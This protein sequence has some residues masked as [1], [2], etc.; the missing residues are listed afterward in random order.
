MSIRIDLRNK[1]RILG[2]RGV[3]AAHGGFETFAEV[4]SLHLVRRGWDVVV[5]CQQA[6]DPSEA[7]ESKLSRDTWQGVERIHIP[8]GL[9]G[10]AGTI[11][12]D[13]KCTW[14]VLQHE[15]CICLILGYNT[16][17][18]SLLYRLRGRLTIMNMDGLEWRRSKWPWPVR[19]WFY[20]NERFGC[21][22]SNHL[23]ADNPEIARRLSQFVPKG[24]VTMIPYGADSIESADVSVLSRFGVQ[25]SRYALV[26]ARAEPE[27]S[28]LEIVSAFSRRPRGVKLI[29]I[30]NYE[31]KRYSYHRKVLQAASEEVL[32]PG[33]IYEAKVIRAL[34]YW[35]TLY[36]HGHRVGGTNPSLV[37]ALGAG[38]PV[39][40]HDNSFNRW[41][42]GQ[43]GEY[44][45]DE[46]S[47]ARLLDQ[48]LNNVTALRR[49]GAASR[50]RHA[51]T[52]CWELPLS[53]YENL[54]GQW[55]DQVVP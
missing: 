45:Q 6:I 13:L 17:M 10:P 47:C 4:L 2:T 46:D 39:I 27:N 28:I 23:I 53:T 9:A 49:M 33:T 30:G 25:A 26:V 14:H 37:E 44:F 43:A 50:Q 54:L 21:W 55:A 19:G 22:F 18:L 34:R 12:F 42:L 52:F 35:S 20:L 8:V 3:P 51:D 32:F 5:Y 7:G 29:V 36:I 1:L 11:E 24:K 16:A 15:P 38:N 31:E 48:L 41:T 40:A